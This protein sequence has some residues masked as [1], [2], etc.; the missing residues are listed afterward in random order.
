MNKKLGI[1]DVQLGK[2]KV[3]RLQESLLHYHER[4]LLTGGRE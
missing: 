2:E 1:D 3:E 4:S